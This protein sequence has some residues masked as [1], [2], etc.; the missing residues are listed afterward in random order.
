MDDFDAYLLATDPGFR[1]LVLDEL[2][3]LHADQ[4][5]A[6]GAGPLSARGTTLYD[7]PL[8][9]PVPSSVASPHLVDSEPRPPRVAMR[10]WLWIALFVVVIVPL[11]ALSVNRV[12]W[13]RAGDLVPAREPVHR[14]NHS[15]PNNRVL[16]APTIS[17]DLIDRVLVTYH[18]PAAG[19]GQELYDLGVQYGIDP[20]F[21]LAFFLHESGFGTRGEARVTLSL[22]NLRCI[23]DNPCID[24]DRGGYAAFS[25]WEDGYQAWYALIRNLY[26]GKW[27]LTTVDQIIP[28]Y[29][30]TADHN[31]VAAYI[32]AVKHAITTWRSGEV[33][34]T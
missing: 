3:R 27:G 10:V 17:P 13:T 4:G 15:C 16:C 30:P 28:R 29:A 26:V 25:S 20:A 2:A 8:L 12:P 24:Q 31:N 23:P 22:G 6:P 18:S 5:P 34:V 32:A 7:A 9:L 1:D 21:A 33:I 14:E 19:T 11:T